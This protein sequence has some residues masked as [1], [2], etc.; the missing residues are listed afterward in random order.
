L[1]HWAASI[2]EDGSVRVYDMANDKVMCHTKYPS[3]GSSLIWAPSS[4]DINGYTLITGHTDGVVR[5]LKINETTSSSKGG[6]SPSGKLSL[7]IAIKPHTQ[8]V[9]SLSVDKEGNILATG[10]D[11][12]TVFFINIKKECSP[13]GFV[14]VPSAVAHIEWNISNKRQ[15]K[16]LVCCK[17]GS[18]LEVCPPDVEGAGPVDTAQSYHLTSLGVVGRKMV[19]IKD[20]LRKEEAE[21]KR[22]KEREEKRKKRLEEKEAK[23]ERRKKEMGDDYESEEEPDEIEE[24]DDDG[25]EEE[26]EEGQEKAESPD[27]S[28]LLT[29]FYDKLDQTKFWISMGGY[30]AGYLYCYSLDEVEGG[31]EIIPYEPQ[32]SIPIP[33]SNGTDRPL[34]SIIFSHSGRYMLTGSD[35]G[36]VRV[37]LLSSFHSLSQLNTHWSISMHDNH[38]GRLS[39]ISLSFDDKYL[40]TGGGDGNVFIY[41]TNFSK[42]KPIQPISGKFADEGL[43]LPSDIVDDITDPS[44]YSI[45]DAK[46]KEEHDRKMK[47]AEAKKQKV[48]RE[49]VLLRRTYTD[50]QQRSQHLPSH[51]RLSKDEFI[52]DPSIGQQLLAQLRDKLEL[53]ER[54]MA[55]ESEKHSLA[56]K[57]LQVKYKDNVECDRIVVWTISDD[58]SDR[59]WVSTFR[60]VSPSPQYLAL[61][62]KIM[63]SDA[64]STPGTAIMGEKGTAVRR[65]TRIIDPLELDGL[66]EETDGDFDKELSKSELRRLRREKRK[67]EWE[68]LYQTKPGDQYEDPEE[69][70]AIERATQRMGD[71][72]LKTST[73][74]V[75]SDQQRMSTEKKRRELIICRYH[76]FEVKKSFNQ[77]L[78]ALRDRKIKLVDKIRE[79]IKELNEIQHRLPEFLHKPIPAVPE[80]KHE[81]IPEKELEY[82]KE[83]LLKFK[84]D[85]KARE[86]AQRQAANEGGEGFGGFGGFGGEGNEEEDESTSSS[87][88]SVE[89]TKKDQP[90]DANAPSNDDLP[91]S[92]S[93]SLTDLEKLL[94][95]EEEIELTHKR[96]SILRDMEE[97]V[98]EF[99]G[100]VIHLRHEKYTID[101]T[102]K[103]MELKHLRQFEEIEL[104]KEFE[105]RETNFTSKYKTKKKEKADLEEKIEEAEWEVQEKET[106][107]SQLQEQEKNLDQAFFEA[108]GEN[109]KFKDFLVKVYRKKI[110]R[111]KQRMKEE[112]EATDENGEEEEETESEYSSS[113][114]DSDDDEDGFDDSTCP[115][116]CDPNLFNQTIQMREK[117][118]DQEELLTEEKK[119][120]DNLKKE[121]DSHMKKSKTVESHVKNALQD[122]QAFQLKKQQRLNELDAIVILRTHQILHYHGNGEPP[123]SVSQCLV[124]SDTA[125]KGLSQRI[126]ELGVEK[127]QEKKRYKELR[128]QHVKLVRERK[129]MDVKVAALNEKANEMMMLKFGRIVNL[130]A[131]EGLTTNKLI[132]ELEEV[133]KEEN[134]KYEKSKK[135]IER[136]VSDI[137]DELLVEIR[138][139]T[140]KLD[141]LNEVTNLCRQ[142]EEELN[143]RQKNLEMDDSLTGGLYD[144]EEKRRLGDIVDIQSREIQ[145]LQEEIKILSH[146][147][148]HILPPT[149][150]PHSLSSRPPTL[151]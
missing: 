78:L 88:T 51:L 68:E 116:G 89:N 110:K 137:Q 8:S 14:V 123:T 143:E 2:A 52:M 9:T 27:P 28:S 148:G 121:R 101:V 7:L 97:R 132:G 70:A 122:L 63:S 80:L 81:E 67:K 75:V 91:S 10:S 41:K 31:G 76:I 136:E 146:K 60:C 138:R 46:Q 44:H 126:T 30:D 130:E 84:K 50:L 117:R 17:D 15:T 19:S 141:E 3:G 104:L 26:K 107:V 124:F 135:K 109:N 114:E 16:L 77:K 83:T 71:Y 129:G 69:V 99:N 82:T 119:L 66:K 40:I 18:V 93:S 23:R 5:L 115:P 13:I 36:R 95:Q 47:A 113:E 42:S 45:E 145:A 38:Y 108:V 59:Y 73:D 144:M 53:V 87:L 112:K 142:L 147:G 127:Q 103:M 6:W 57:K 32:S 106:L 24:E 25:E 49:I 111:A 1:K 37:H 58:G 22:A 11:D 86:K 94:A 64:L 61:L 54:E 56:L 33:Q 105:K 35:D 139:H 120:L 4:V 150:P 39:A 118:L 29:A 149:Q 20:R 102:M 12:G 96:D 125:M 140:E 55:W 134:K 65:K 79:W 48:R 43:S 74:Y 34:H 100:A 90:T 133:L 131:L 62:D 21:L 128:H 85:F 151:A 98:S 92:L 72:K